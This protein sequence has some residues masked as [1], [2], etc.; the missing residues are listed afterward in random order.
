MPRMPG[1]SPGPVCPALDTP[2]PTVPIP[3]R[4]P[5]WMSSGVGE[6]ITPP[7]CVVTPAVCGY[8]FV[9]ESVPESACTLP[10]VVNG[11]FNLVVPAPA[12]FLNVAAA[13]LMNGPAVPRGLVIVVSFL[14]SQVPVFVIDAPTTE[15][16]PA[17]QVVVPAV[18]STREEVRP[19]NPLIAIPPLVFV[20]PAPAIVPPDHVV[21]PDTV[22]VPGPPSVPPEKTSDVGLMAP[23]RLLALA[24]ANPE[25]VSE[26]PLRLPP[27]FTVP[28]FTATAGTLTLEVVPRSWV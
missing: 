19:T 26:P 22:T 14:Q 28:L 9:N 10:P 18:L 12:D 17:V 11:T 1:E 3:W 4:T 27:K 2:A 21:R 6:V 25:I 16:S 24:V 20:V 7:F 15:I 13:A 23:A 5:P 8:P